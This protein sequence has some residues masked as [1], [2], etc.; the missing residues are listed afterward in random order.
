MGCPLS[1]CELRAIVLLALL[2]ALATPAGACYRFHVWRYPWPQRCDVHGHEIAQPTSA[3]EPTIP[4]PFLDDIQW[5]GDFYLKPE[6]KAR[7]LLRGELEP[8]K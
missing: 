5:N 8:P 6:M 4:L 3:K 2:L 1:R 7:L